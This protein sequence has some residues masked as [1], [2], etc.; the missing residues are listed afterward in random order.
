MRV[1]LHLR[2]QC[3][4]AATR[5]DILKRGGGR[6]EV[7]SPLNVRA[8]LTLSGAQIAECVETIKINYKDFRVFFLLRPTQA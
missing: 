6:R 3:A 1:D 5:T 8:R 4:Y 2:C 7:Q